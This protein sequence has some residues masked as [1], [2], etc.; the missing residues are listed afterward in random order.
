MANIC[1]DCSEKLRL[2]GW[3]H[4]HVLESL[5]TFYDLSLFISKNEFDNDLN[6]VNTFRWLEMHGYVIS[7]EADHRN[8]TYYKINT[9]KAIFCCEKNEIC[10]CRYAQRD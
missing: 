10:W 2:V 4:L 1:T 3:S 5:C 6:Q 7:T 9:N 8:E